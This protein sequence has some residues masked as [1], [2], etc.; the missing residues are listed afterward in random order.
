MLEFV[1]TN[2]TKNKYGVEI[3]GPSSE[4]GKVIYENT[5]NLDNVIFSNDTIWSKHNNKYNFY[6]NKIGNVIINDA[7]NINNIDNG[8]YDFLFASHCL[9]HIANPIKALVEWLRIIKKT[10]YLI[11][12]LP[13]NSVTFDHKR[14][15]SSFETL[16]KQYKN[17]VGEDDLST[18]PEILENHDLTMDL[19][20]GNYEQFKQRSLNNY[21]NRALHHYV[22]DMKLLM[23]LCDY[24]KCEYIYSE[25]DGINIWF[26]LKKINYKFII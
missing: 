4:T 3:G 1:L 2:I 9:E 20:A 18:L 19:A 21:N 11:L 16:L 5:L 25:T 6:G 26:I 7:V 22:Y 15:I 8:S 13:E 10:G 14:K 24:L 17:N 12:I 23:K